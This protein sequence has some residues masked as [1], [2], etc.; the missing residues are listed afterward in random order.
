MNNKNL[1]VIILAAGLG[2]RMNS[3]ELPKVLADLIGKPLIDY[4]IQSALKLE[5]QKIV[6]IVGYH[7]EK[8]KQYINS[9][10]YAHKIEYALQMEQLG[11]GHAV[12]QTFPLLKDFDGDAL[13]LCGDVPLLNSETLKSLIDYHDG[14]S[15]DVTVLSAVAENPA[16]YGRIIRD[17]NEN[18]LAIIEQKDAQPDQLLIQEI[19]SGVYLVDCKMLYEA[20]GG[21][22]NSNAQGE[23]YLTDIIKIISADGGKVA[24]TPVQDF[25]EIIGINTADD[26]AFVQ[27]LIEGGKND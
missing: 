22:N 23:Y 11:T 14:I 6:V 13:I 2:K 24:A 26:L 16:G 20:L 10:P 3:P 15:A 21:V 5:P 9:Q 12:K 25:N 18:F 27:K 19:N 4:V 17:E 7:G 8:V 1:A